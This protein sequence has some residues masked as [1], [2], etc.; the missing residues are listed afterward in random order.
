MQA[1]YIC[2]D[3]PTQLNFMTTVIENYLMM[4][5]LMMKVELAT[6]NPDELLQHLAY[7]NAENGIYFLDIELSHSMDG[8]QLAQAIRQQDDLGKIIFITTHGEYAPVTFRYK[9]EALDYII[10]STPEKVQAQIIECL[11]VIEDRQLVNADE[12]Q[13]YIFKSGTKTRSVPYESILYVE[14]LPQP[15]KVALHTT[16]GNY[17]FYDSLK[18]VEAT[19]DSFVR[20]HRSFVANLN[21]IESIDRGQQTVLFKDGSTCP[22]AT[23][24]AGQIVKLLLKQHE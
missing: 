20:V 5:E 6:Q 2:E 11:Q 1:I 23:R 10:K 13:H 24:R 21:M 22:L 19:A 7:T 15:H 14:S 12:K 3:D 9:V 8:I 18:A 17:Q 16:H 4:E